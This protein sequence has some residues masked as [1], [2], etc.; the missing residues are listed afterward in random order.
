VT[1]YSNFLMLHGPNAN[2]VNSVIHWHQGQTTF[3]RRILDVMGH[4]A[5]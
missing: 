4:R 1:L 3:A 5:R 2:R